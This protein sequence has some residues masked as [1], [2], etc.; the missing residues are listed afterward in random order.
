MTPSETTVWSV[1]LP[2]LVCMPM[3]ATYMQDLTIIATIEE[4]G[5]GG[6]VVVLWQNSTSTYGVLRTVLRTTP[7]E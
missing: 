7:Y 6:Y 1:D 4:R 2:A 3:R 5:I